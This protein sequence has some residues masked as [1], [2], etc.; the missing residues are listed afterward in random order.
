VRR[1]Q[2]VEQDGSELALKIE[3]AHPICEFVRKQFL[4]TESVHPSNLTDRLPGVRVLK[5]G[6][7]C[8]VHRNLACWLKILVGIVH[9]YIN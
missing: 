3:C 7:E 1:L 6:Q 2:A 5:I 4:M 8:S 9:L